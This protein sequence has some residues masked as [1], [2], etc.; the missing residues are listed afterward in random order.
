M[1]SRRAG[2]S[3]LKPV[4]RCAAVAGAVLLALAS[5]TGLPSAA[6]AAPPTVAAS[7]EARAAAPFALASAADPSP[8]VDPAPG[9][10]PEPTATTPT[11]PTST[12]APTA[13]PTGAPG[14]TP[15]LTDPV[16][17]APVTPTPAP[18]V[19]A[20]APVLPSLATPLGLVYP[21]NPWISNGAEGTRFL[22]ERER[23][24]TG[25][26]VRRHLGTDAQGGVRQPIFAVADGTVVAGT[27]GSTP[28]DGNGWGNYL[29]IS[30]DGGY[31]SLYAHFES[32]PLVPLGSRVVAGQL[33]GYMG[34]TQYGNPNGVARHL[35]L[36]VTQDGRFI[37]PLAF[38]EGAQ[39]A[40]T[41]A[42]ETA[43]VAASAGPV[44]EEFALT[45]LAPT[46]AGS[47]TSTPTGLTVASTVF[48]AIEAASGAESAD[49]LVSENGV[50]VRLSAAGG[51]WTKTDT[52]IPLAATSLAGTRNTAGRIE[53]FAV[54]DG[55]LLSIVE[56]A[57]GWTKTDM[58]RAFAGEVRAVRMPD[59]GARVLLAR[60][61]SLYE[62]TAADGG[63]WNIVDAGARV[64]AA[65]DAVSVAGG[66][67][68]VMTVLDG[69]VVRLVNDGS[70]WRSVPTGLT[71]SGPLAAFAGTGSWPA[72]I[73]VERGG[74]AFTGVVDGWWKQSTA[75]VAVSGAIDAVPGA[76]PAPL[77]YTIG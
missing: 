63:L 26:V 59:G 40:A 20:F 64:G 39:A 32:A 22:D 55:R 16:P 24:A 69:Q 43:P 37:D 19:G 4:R 61:G 8:T 14:S 7:A 47:Y 52:Q 31:T 5:I 56:G 73:T 46:D 28:R 48:T 17:A 72:A 51:V 15:S 75:G 23:D 68:D 11:Q 44:A 33:I 3:A 36:E 12:P 65:F 53:L 71:A 50:L 54:E 29:R 74:L 45:E 42:P 67:P 60:A 6:T 66:A 25:Q 34:G 62:L 21:T 27:W 10:T 9:P 18:P 57:T 35:H 13:A 49:I 2:R 77:V 1:V 41:I 70:V 38:L 30:H 58:G 76:G